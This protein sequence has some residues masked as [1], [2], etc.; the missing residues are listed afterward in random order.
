MRI[1]YIRVSTDEQNIERQ[2]TALKAAGVEKIF[3]DKLKGEMIYG[4]QKL[5]NYY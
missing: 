4:K 2:E 5:N 3:I 1:G